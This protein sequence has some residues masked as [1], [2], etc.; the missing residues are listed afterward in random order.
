MEG[1]IV[2][3]LLDGSEV[4]FVEQLFA[5]TRPIPIGHLALGLQRVKQ[6]KD[7][8]AQGRHAGASTDVDHLP[9]GF[10]NEELAVG[11]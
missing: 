3:L 2:G 1:E 8:R 7:V 11:S 9:L 6:V 4:V 5:G 10:L